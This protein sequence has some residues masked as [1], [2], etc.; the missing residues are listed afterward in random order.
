VENNELKQVIKEN[1]FITGGAIPSLLMGERPND[2]D[3]YFKTPAAALK[4]AEYYTE[5]IANGQAYEIVEGEERVLVKIPSVGVLRNGDLEGA[6]G[7]V[8]TI[9]AAKPFSPLYITDNAI[10]LSNKMQLVLRFCGE[11]SVVHKYYDFIHATCVYDYF[12]GELTLPPEALESIL[13]KNLIYR[14]SLYPVASIFRVRK[15]LKRGWHITAGQ[16]LKPMLQ[17]SQMDLRNT[18][19]LR[20]QL[21]GVDQMFMEQ[22]L[23]AIQNAKGERLDDMY[24]A[25]LIDEIFDEDL[26]GAE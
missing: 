21:I 1:A 3:V 4:A 2:Y 5:K 14:G 23:M 10:T 26:G 11:P 20:D 22:L 15:F 6:M 17:I 25:K 7:A 18:E 13:G 19:V 16:L 24:L 9:K 12:N 8:E